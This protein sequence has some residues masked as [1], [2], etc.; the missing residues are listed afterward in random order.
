[1]TMMRRLPWHRRVLV[2]GATGKTGTRVAERLWNGGLGVRPGHRGAERP[3]DWARPESW[4]PALEGV[5]AVYV[6]YQP[7]LA[8]PEA[9]WRVGA[10][11]RQA[12]AAGARRLV[13]LSGRGEAG[14]ERAEAA[15]RASGAD[16]T[17]LRASW[18]MQNFSEGAFAPALADGALALP[19]GE[20]GEP[21]VDAEDVAEVA[22][23]ALADDRFLGRVLELTGPRLLSVREAV[24]EIAAASARPMTFR[25]ATEAGFAADLAARGV[26]DDVSALLLGLFGTLFDG[27]N[28]HATTAVADLLGRPARD[29]RDFAAEAARA[30]AWGAAGEPAP[31]RLARA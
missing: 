15:L 20:V 3:F 18:F 10:F 17:V 28:A 21:F 30:G 1:M 13:L 5:Q 22:A 7:D 11:A 19:V 2:L 9:A 6:T 24:A 8:A 16:W 29:F 27:R 12:V 31:P 25:R 23:L 14:A 26:A 4:G